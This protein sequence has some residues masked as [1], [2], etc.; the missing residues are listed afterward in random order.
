MIIANL[1]PQD[2]RNGSYSRRK[3]RAHAGE[4]EQT[5]ASYPAATIHSNVVHARTNLQL[6]ASCHR[7]R[8]AMTAPCSAAMQ[9]LCMIHQYNHMCCIL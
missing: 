9:L 7:D 5:I 4:R 2:V 3:M 6:V 8:T 1:Y